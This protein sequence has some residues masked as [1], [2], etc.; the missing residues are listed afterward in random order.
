MRP[1]ILVVEDE[2]I[3]AHDIKGILSDDYDVI[4]NIKTVEEAISIIEKEHFDLVLLDINLKAEKQGTVFGE[5]L[6]KKDT[7]PF[8]YITS[9]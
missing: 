2:I 7:I 5:Y 8:I 9:S 1:R 3:I 4:I 6:L